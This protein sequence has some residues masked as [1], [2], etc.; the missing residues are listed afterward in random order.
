VDEPPLLVRLLSFAHDWR[1]QVRAEEENLGPL[2]RQFITV[3]MSSFK[4]GSYRLVVRVKDLRSGRVATGTARFEH[5][6]DAPAVTEG[7]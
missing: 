3:P 1:Y 7:E 6:A 4:P 2:R 5:V